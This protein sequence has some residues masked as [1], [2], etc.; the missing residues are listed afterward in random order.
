MRPALAQERVGAQVISARYGRCCRCTLYRPALLLVRLVARVAHDYSFARVAKAL[1]HFCARVPS[2]SAVAPVAF[3]WHG[4][5]KPA[6]AKSILR[7]LVALVDAP[8]VVLVALVAGGGAVP[9]LRYAAISGPTAD[10]QEPFDWRTT[11]CDVDA[12]FGQPER[13][14]FSWTEL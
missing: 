1:V 3:V 12:H 6:R 2:H 9:S 4:E 7:T 10:E 14:D 8:V 13:F 5:E 11:K